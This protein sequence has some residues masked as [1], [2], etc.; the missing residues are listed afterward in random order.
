MISDPPGAV[1]LDQCRSFIG[2]FCAMPSQ[3]A[4]DLAT[5]WVAH[6][7]AVDQNDRLAFDTSPRLMFSSEGPG[8]GKSRALELVQLLSHNGQLVIDPTAPSFAQLAS[9]QRATILVDEM[10][11]L[12]GRGSG[13][14][15]L[16]SLFNASYKK[17]TAIWSRAGKPAVPI[18]AA[19]GFAG[20]GAT[21]RS[22]PVLSA[23][24]SRTLVVEMVPG[25]PPE[26]YRP[27]VHDPLADALRAEL[28]KWVG[29][30]TS[31]IIESLPDMPEDL[32]A[33]RAA[34]LAEPL[35]MLAEIAGGHW[36]ETARNAVQEVMLGR[37]AEP[38]ALPLSSQLLADIA[39]VFGDA[40]QIGT[41][42]LVEALCALPERPWAT[43]WPSAVSA[44]K[45]LAGML[46]PLGVTPTRI[47]V[48]GVQ[49]RG[50]LRSAFVPLW[51]EELVTRDASQLG[52]DEDNEASHLAA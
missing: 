4:L 8:S 47:R 25:M 34:E 30:N 36:P 35:I 40:E 27:R 19:V 32:T 45:D 7:H 52:D 29:R 13:K 51:G 11:V 48:D 3:A 16:R 46:E 44:P 28:G 1:I 20:M 43:V 14:A 33:G 18:F 50:Y 39:A 41:V 42:D 23:L 22:A 31:R 5:L 15:D 12:I 26:S 6:T 10:D 17:K 2:R 38:D 49:V 9:E 24:R 21:F 37:S